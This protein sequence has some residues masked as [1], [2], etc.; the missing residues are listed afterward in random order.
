MAGTSTISASRAE[1]VNTSRSLPLRNCHAE[2]ASMIIEPVTRAAKMTFE[3]PHR[4][5]GLVNS[6]QMSLS[7]GLPLTI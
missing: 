5:T 1:L 7:C 6:A 3:Y 2:T 4:N